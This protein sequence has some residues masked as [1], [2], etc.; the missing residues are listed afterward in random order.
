MILAGIVTVLLLYEI[1]SGWRQGVVRQLVSLAALAAG[2]FGGCAVAPKAGRFLGFTGLPD[3]VLQPLGG[4]VAGVVIFV[5]VRFMGRVLF[6]RT[7]EQG[8]GVIWFI[9]GAGGAVLGLLFGLAL[10]WAALI[11]MR[12]VGAF[13]KGTLEGDEAKPNRA[14]LLAVALRERVNEGRAGEWISLVDPVNAETYASAEQW[15]RV[16]KQPMALVRALSS[17]EVPELAGLPQLTALKDDPQVAAALQ[18]GNYMALLR[19]P[20]VVEAM[21]HPEVAKALKALNLEALMGK[22]A[23]PAAPGE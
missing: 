23:G 16:A 6:R 1:I 9:Y 21:N 8:L 10:V 3:L 17:P 13:A 11:G 5:A 7:S 18:E 2:W 15:G 12:V 4:V 19:H 22:E 14:A 20:K